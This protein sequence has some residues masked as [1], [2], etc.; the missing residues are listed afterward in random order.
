MENHQNF[1]IEND[2]LTKYTG[3]GGDV[4]IPVGIT[5]I[6]EYALYGCKKLTIYAPTGSYA[7]RYAMEKVIIWQRLVFAIRQI[8]KQLFKF[9]C[10]TYAY[11]SL[12]LF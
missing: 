12:L 6:D 10:I 3:P 9:S 2:V 8:S 7:W 4:S 1:I 5:V 11:F